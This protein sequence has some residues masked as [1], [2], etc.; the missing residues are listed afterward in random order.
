M[1]NTMQAKL[2]K[3]WKRLSQTQDEDSAF[4]T[5]TAFVKDTE[6]ELI[7]VVTALQAHIDVLHDE[8]IRNQLPVERFAALD[9]AVTRII[10]DT[11]TLASVSE[12]AHKPLSTQK[13]TLEM[14]ISE[15]VDE[16]RSAFKKSQV[17]LS[18]N[19]AKGTTLIGN[20]G[21]MKSM[22]KGIVLTVLDK[23]HQTETLSIVGLTHKKCVS[24]SFGIGLE[25]GDGEFTPWELGKLRL[26][27]ANG[28]GITMS[29]VDA[30][31]RLNHG[32]L[33]V[34]TSTDQRQGYRLRFNAI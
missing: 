19:I 14:L 16:T 18:C 15:I 27:P 8:Q 7:S 24:L 1:N 3:L 4:D 31:A 30:M 6:H 21:S 26:L 17:T 13:L 20:A 32:N 12:Q 25:T 9:R 10:S 33:S 5:L 34:R 23:C 29:T 28:E 11:N 22:I 2:A